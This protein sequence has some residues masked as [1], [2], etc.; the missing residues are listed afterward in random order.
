MPFIASGN[1][2]NGENVL[3]LIHVALAKEAVRKD[4]L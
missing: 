1:A 4:H 3:T 2:G